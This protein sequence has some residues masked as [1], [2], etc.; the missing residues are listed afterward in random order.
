[1]RNTRAGW[2][3]GWL[4]VAVLA[5]TM[6]F[7]S[8]F[9]DWMYK[10]KL[11]FSGYEGTETLKNF[12]ALVVLSSDTISGFD[13]ADCAAGGAD[14]VFLMPMALKFPTR[15]RAGTERESRTSG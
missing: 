3:R 4:T 13:H 2:V 6:V 12:P 15:L 14:S 11:I 10:S 9:G 5:T 7:G 1:M 8:P